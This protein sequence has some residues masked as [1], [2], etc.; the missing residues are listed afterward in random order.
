MTPTVL[1]GFLDLVVGTLC[2]PT[3]P[4]AVCLDRVVVPDVAAQGNVL[5]TVSRL[6]HEVPRLDTFMR[7]VLELLLLE[8]DETLQHFLE[9]VLRYSLLCEEM[10][11]IAES[12]S[13][14]M[15]WRAAGLW[16]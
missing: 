9:L 3:E 2:A 7:P 13:D 6:Q 4:L 14:Q 10:Q 12:A 15:A 5:E 1:P 8:D 16:T 11:G